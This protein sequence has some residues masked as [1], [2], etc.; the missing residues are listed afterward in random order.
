VPRVIA[1]DVW[2]CLRHVLEVREGLT[3]E[4][5]RHAVAYLEQAFEFCEAASNPQ[6][7][8]RPLLYYYSFLNAAKAYL[9]ACGKPLPPQTHHGVQDPKANVRQRLWLEGQKVRVLA[10]S[11]DGSNILPEFIAVLDG[12]AQRQ[13]EYAVLDG[14]L[15][16]VPAIHRTYTKVRRCPLRFVPVKDFELLTDGRE[17]WT[18]A[19][20]DATDNDV[21]RALPSVQARTGFRGVFDRVSAP[22]GLVWFESRP[23]AGQRRGVDTAVSRLAG[24]IRRCGVWSLLTGRGYR[25]YFGDFPPTQRLP[26]LASILSVM[27]YL[28]SITRYKPYDFDRIVGG[29]YAWLVSEF[30]ATQ[31]QQFLYLLA[32]NL[33]GVDVVRPFAIGSGG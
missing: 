32:S 29:R 13:R 1:G 30:L 8:A 9:L 2:A 27:F 12:D 18:R 21:T 24:E 33:A 17:V 25:H 23:E 5:K 7:G 3:K 26:Q 19:V 11:S 15:A 10:V 22:S 6:I 14:L 28:G 20:L 4:Q 31:P 16:Q